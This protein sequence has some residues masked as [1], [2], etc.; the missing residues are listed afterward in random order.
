MPQ[1]GDQISR[2]ADLGTYPLA[3]CHQLDL[4]S[5][6]GIITKFA[7]LAHSLWTYGISYMLDSGIVEKLIVNFFW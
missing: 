1:I 3:V 4:G 7:F 6:M 2:L 5:L